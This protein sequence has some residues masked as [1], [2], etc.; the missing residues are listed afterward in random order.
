VQD[1]IQVLAYRFK[2]GDLQMS[3]CLEIKE[4]VVELG[5][6]KCPVGLSCKDICQYMVV[7]KERKNGMEWRGDGRI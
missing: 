4:R 2:K 5:R 6:R 1:D 7:G 3:N